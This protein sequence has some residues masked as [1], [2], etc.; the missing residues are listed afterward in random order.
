MY[1][2]TLR[3]VQVIITRDSLTHSLYA[4]SGEILEKLT[5]FKLVK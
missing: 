5:G 1:N 3:N 4:W 2:V